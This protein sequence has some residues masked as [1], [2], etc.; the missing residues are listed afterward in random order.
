MGRCILGL[1][2]WPDHHHHVRED[3][4]TEREKLQNLRQGE[5]IEFEHYGHKFY[6]RV[7]EYPDGRPGEVWLSTGKTGTQLAITMQ[8]S[9]IAASLALQFGCPIETLRGAFLRGDDGK[10][11]GPL[12]ALLDLM[13]GGANA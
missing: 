10:P 13:A 1:R 9:A 12:G 6:G 5:T 8:D 3:A 7:G 4:L 2:S 11:A